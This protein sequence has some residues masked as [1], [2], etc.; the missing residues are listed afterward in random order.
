[1]QDASGLSSG[2]E[3]P[4]SW[5]AFNLPRCSDETHNAPAFFPLQTRPTDGSTLA[6]EICCILRA[7]SGWACRT[8]TMLRASGTSN[9]QALRKYEPAYHCI[10]RFL[11]K[12]T[13]HIIALPIFIFI[14]GAHPHRKFCRQHK[15]IRQRLGDCH[16]VETC[17]PQPFRTF[18]WCC[19]RVRI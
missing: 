1:M 15:S 9:A 18:K 16:R 10:I 2:S 5:Y 13:A 3:K 8:T 6:P 17:R 12:Y 19:Q 4:S 7:P 11:L 14:C